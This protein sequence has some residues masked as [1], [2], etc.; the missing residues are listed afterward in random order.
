MIINNENRYQINSQ[1]SILIILKKFIDKCNIVYIEVY[2][3]EGGH[4]EECK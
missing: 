2:L 3:S 4:D 1:F